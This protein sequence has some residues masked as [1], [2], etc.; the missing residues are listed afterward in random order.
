[1]EERKSRGL[2]IREACIGQRRRGKTVLKLNNTYLNIEFHTHAYIEKW[3]TAKCGQYQPK[4]GQL[5]YRQHLVNFPTAPCTLLHPV[6]NIETT[7]NQLQ[8]SLFTHLCVISHINLLQQGAGKGK[9]IVEGLV[10]EGTGHLAMFLQV[11][12]GL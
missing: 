11:P 2:L 8:H 6:D 3:C 10:S 5:K 12:H 7:G 4:W 9:D 1:M